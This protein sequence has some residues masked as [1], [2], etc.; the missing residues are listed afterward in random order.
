MAR[1]EMTKQQEKVFLRCVMAAIFLVALG[2]MTVLPSVSKK[3][4]PDRFI[5]EMK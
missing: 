2:G 3:A 1:P 5:V 4:A